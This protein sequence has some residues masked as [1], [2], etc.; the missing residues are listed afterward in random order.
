MTDNLDLQE[1]KESENNILDE[2]F[3]PGVGGFKT[4]IRNGKS[5]TET[6]TIDE[7]SN[8]LKNAV[9]T[10]TSN[11]DM[12][13]LAWSDNASRMFPNIDPL[14]YNKRV[15]VLVN[16]DY[17]KPFLFEP[18][19]VPKSIIEDMR[20][21]NGMVMRIRPIIPLDANDK[22]KAGYRVHKYLNSH[23]VNFLSPCGDFW[24]QSQKGLVM[25]NMKFTQY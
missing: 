3:P 23:A 11:K 1:N 24:G 5:V 14:T 25:F 13:I 16:E 2:I 21:C 8:E 19:Q 15:L 6:M 18:N 17:F 20:T 10:L 4:T 22:L 12:E 9:S 7:A